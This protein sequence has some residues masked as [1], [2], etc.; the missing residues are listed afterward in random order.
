M[1]YP[2][3]SM[4][5]NITG[6]SCTADAGVATSPTLDGKRSRAETARSDM[7]SAAT[8]ADKYLPVASSNTTGTETIQK[9]IVFCVTATL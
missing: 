9:W 5:S 3:D 7:C 6:N 4:Y 8:T 1:Q 2:A